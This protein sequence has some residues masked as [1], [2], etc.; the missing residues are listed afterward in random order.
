MPDVV[1]IRAGLVPYC[2]AAELQRQLAA[3][4][5]AEE[6]PD[7]LLLL[8]HPPVFTRGRRTPADHLPM[9][10][11]W[12]RER[13]VEVHETDRGGQV[14]YHGPGQLV[15]YPIIALRGSE[16]D[17]HAYV[18]GLEQVIIA[19]LNEAGVPA[20]VFAG[21]TGVWTAGAPPLA[22]GMAGPQ[23][24]PVGTPTLPGDAAARKVGSIG[25][26]VSRWVTTHGL[27]INVDCDLAPFEWIVPCGIDAV[28]VSSIERETGRSAAIGGV[29]D[30]VVATFAELFGRR[31]VD[32]DPGTLGAL[33]AAEPA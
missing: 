16:R 22:P 12:Y 31:P 20:Q 32:G 27:A 29:A 18:R 2:E 9:G 4:R 28:E 8:E 19:A 13:G 10:D 5:Q 23:R 6:I 17:L 11:A 26:H 14:T 1:V 24:T 7:Q 3:A 21:L 15:A 25:I 30:S 33:V